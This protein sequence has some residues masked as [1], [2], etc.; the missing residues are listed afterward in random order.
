MSRLWTAAT[1]AAGW[2]VVTRLM[3]DR[4]SRGTTQSGPVSIAW[5]VNRGS[6]A[7]GSKR[8]HPWDLWVKVPGV[9][10]P[11]AG[12]DPRVYGAAAAGGYTWHSFH[13]TFAAAI[14]RAK[15]L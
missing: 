11:H 12:E 1:V 2:L 3:R 14:D 15:T 13:K 6:A 8:K 4:E 9:T 5:I 7:L 10:G